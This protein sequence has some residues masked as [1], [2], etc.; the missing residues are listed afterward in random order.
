M[1]RLIAPAVA[2][3]APL[4]AGSRLIPDTPSTVP[5]DMMIEADLVGSE[6]NQSW[7]ARVSQSLF[8]NSQ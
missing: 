4:T 5:V 6:A 3:L 8:R 2:L 7:L 1:N